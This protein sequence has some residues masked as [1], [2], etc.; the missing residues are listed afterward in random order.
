MVLKIA[1]LFIKVNYQHDLVKE[2]SKKYII[3]NYAHID[4]DLDDINTDK[5]LVK[6]K[7][8]VAGAAI[9]YNGKAYL[10][11]GPSGI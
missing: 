8:E 4:I 1:N 7:L 5:Y 11:I 9:E 6:N 3:N 2:L 10:F